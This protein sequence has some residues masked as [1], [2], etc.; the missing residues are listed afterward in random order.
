M[1]SDAIGRQEYKTRD[2]TEQAEKPLLH[3]RRVDLLISQLI[4]KANHKFA[5]S[6][7]SPSPV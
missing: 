5:F 4:P 1:D 2:F 7:C 3:G 6:G